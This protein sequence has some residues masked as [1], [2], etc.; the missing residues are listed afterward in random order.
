MQTNTRKKERGRERDTQKSTKKFS[1]NMIE[2]K[3]VRMHE[4]CMNM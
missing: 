3:M 2:T 4:K 1:I